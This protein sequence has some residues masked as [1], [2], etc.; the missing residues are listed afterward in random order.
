MNQKFHKPGFAERFRQLGYLL[1]NTVTIIGRNTGIVGPWLRTAVYAAV[2]VTIFFSCIAAYALG[3]GWIGA[4]LLLVAFAMFVYK[5]FYYIRQDMAQSWMVTQTVRGEDAAP[6]DGHQRVHELKSQ[7]RGLGWAA[8]AFAFM[9]S[10]AN[11]DQDSGFKGVIIGLILAGLAEVWDLARHFLAPVITVDGYSLR[12]SLGQLKRLR[13]AVPE[14]LV[15]VF[16]IDIAGGAVAA[17]MVPIYLLLVLAAIWLGLLVGHGVP[18]FYAGDLRAL[19]GTNT[20]AWLGTGALPFNWLPP[21]VALWLG[22]MFGTIFARAVGSL[23][24]I[25]FTLFYMRIAHADEIAPDLREELDG[26]LRVA[27]SPGDEKT[28]PQPS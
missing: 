25:Y 28:A 12:D 21:L 1:K 5:Y 2:M 6:G 17:L 7:A 19:F 27:A 4:V 10:R 14:T 20:P 26:Y 18:A 15:G 9:K 16:G 11:E 3:A 13:N 22:K 8:M 23:K 24:I